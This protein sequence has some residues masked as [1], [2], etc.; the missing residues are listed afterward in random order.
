MNT[1][2]ITCA[3]VFMCAF[4]SCYSSLPSNSKAVRMQPGAGYM[5]SCKAALHPPAETFDVYTLLACEW[6]EEY[7]GSDVPGAAYKEGQAAAEDAD[8]HEDNQDTEDS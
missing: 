5:H 7:P 1:K 2:A 4:T 8:C 3:L 6:P